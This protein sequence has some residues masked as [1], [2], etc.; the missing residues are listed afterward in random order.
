MV[1]VRIAWFSPLPPVK[2]GIAGRSAELIDVLRARGHAIDAYPETRAHDFPW[3]RRLEP[4]DLAV[5]Q[6]GNSSHHDYEWP[7]ALQYPGLTVLHDTHLHHARAALL[8]REKRIDDYR[9]EFRWSHPDLSPDAAE[10]AIA[11]LDSRL[12]YDWPLVRPLLEASRL[13]AVHGESARDELL[14]TSNSA[15]PNSATP[16]SPTPNTQLVELAEKV[17]ALRLGEGELVSPEREERARRDVRARY[18]IERDAVLFGCFGGLTPEKRIKQILG[19]LQAVLP[20]A[21][22]ARLMLAGAPA[23][24]Y[25]GVADAAA[26]GIADHVTF[27]GYLET[28]A[29]LTDHIAAC[30]V[31]LNLRWPTARETSGPWLRALAAGKPTV[32]TDL[33]HL[34]GFDTLDPR[35]W[36]VSGGSPITD[37]GP[38]TTAHG[39][40]P[41]DPVSIAIDILDEDHSLRLAM[42]RLATDA[43]LRAR[44]GRAARECWMREHS[45]D[46]MADDYERIMREAASRPDPGVE[47]PP[48]MRDPGDSRLR[49][50]IR[51]FG[52]AFPF[53]RGHVHA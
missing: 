39:P 24:H 29:A 4:Y 35:T 6:F 30:D 19:A 42:R 44:L 33:V 18:G 13:V 16:N 46:A 53:A 15:P 31:S 47:L 21:P 17:V 51:P 8:L 26:L 48:H 3:R 1:P 37:H 11:G 12:Y 41:T 40:R 38:R 2:T 34:T 32:I 22:S 14:G 27:T 43:D 45:V 20:Y 50:L 25:D 10:I 9:A 36:S 23:P 52:L 28:D 49:T 5:Y 7:Y